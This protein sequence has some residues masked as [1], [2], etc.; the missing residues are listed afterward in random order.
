MDP[1]KICE[2]VHYIQTHPKQCNK[3]FSAKTPAEIWFLFCSDPSLVKD[4]FPNDEMCDWP[5]EETCTYTFAFGHTCTNP[6]ND[7]SDRCPHHDQTIFSK[8][9][10][11]YISQEQSKINH[12][13]REFSAIHIGDGL[14]CDPDTEIALRREEDGMMKCVGR[15]PHRFY[16]PDYTVEDLIPITPELCSWC[17]EREIPHI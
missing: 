3:V 6:R 13:F 8:E 10:R 15:F 9:V 16:G 7:G 12:A 1:R 17:D 5:K 4:D 2:V 14:F 11:D